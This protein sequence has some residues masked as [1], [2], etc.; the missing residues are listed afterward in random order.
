MLVP[1]LVKHNKEN[2]VGDTEA[3]NCAQIFTAIVFMKGIK[4]QNTIVGIMNKYISI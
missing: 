1:F 4:I 3:Q 2:T